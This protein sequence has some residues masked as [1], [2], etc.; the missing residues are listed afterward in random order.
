M[1]RK[2]TR[3]KSQTHLSLIRPLLLMGFK[4]PH[5]DVCIITT[6]AFRRVGSTF[7]IT[8]SL[9]SPGYPDFC[10]GGRCLNLKTIPFHQEFILVIGI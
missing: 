6:R 10:L 7:A 9:I 5:F 4:D 8:R 1:I 3:A 2:R